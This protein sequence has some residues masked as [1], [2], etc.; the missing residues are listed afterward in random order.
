M[1]QR[2]VDFKV[3]SVRS[4]LLGSLTK[5]SIEQGINKLLIQHSSEYFIKPLSPRISEK[6][7]FTIIVQNLVEA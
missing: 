7:A 5:E 6:P 4:Y 3:E 1:R 2:L